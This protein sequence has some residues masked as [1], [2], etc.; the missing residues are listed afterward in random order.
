M[1]AFRLSALVLALYSCNLARPVADAPLSDVKTVESVHHSGK[2]LLWWSPDGDKF[3]VKP[4]EETVPKQ[5]ID[6]LEQM[7]ALCKGTAE[8]TATTRA[9][10]AP[11]MLEIVSDD[12]GFDAVLKDEAK[13]TL[14]AEIQSEIS[15]NEWT[16]GDVEADLASL[17]GQLKDLVQNLDAVKKD[18]DKMRTTAEAAAQA[19]GRPATE[20]DLDLIFGTAYRDVLKALKTAE[21]A[22]DKKKSEVEKQLKA[23]QDVRKAIADARKKLE[24][25]IL[26]VLT[27]IAD[28]DKVTTVSLLQRE[29]LAFALLQTAAIRLKLIASHAPVNVTCKQVC[30]TE[31]PFY[32]R[33]RCYSCRCKEAMDGS[34]PKPEE[35]SCKTAKQIKVYK[36]KTGAQGFELGE[37]E[38][39]ADP[40]AC[41]NPSLLYGD[42]QYGSKLGQLTKGDITYKW[43]CRHRSHPTAAD[44]TYDDVGVIAHNATTGASCW[45]DD[46]GGI[47]TDDKF[48]KLDLTS[49]TQAEID[50]NKEVFYNTTGEGCTGCHDNDPFM[51]S[52]YF[53][54]L[55]WKTGSYVDASYT[56]TQLDGKQ[57]KVERSFLASDEAGACVSCHRIASGSTCASWAGQSMGTEKGDGVEELVHKALDVTPTSGARKAGENWQL[58]Y[59]MPITKGFIKG[60][61]EKWHEKYGEAKTHIEKCCANPQATGCKWVDHQGAE[62]TASTFQDLPDFPTPED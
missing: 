32:D 52:P 44:A 54:S 1:A 62:V 13:R 29:N 39:G 36:L 24:D 45:W 14:M 46:G 57:E 53:A 3:Y 49:A 48:P 11:M 18:L 26:E 43:I 60:T 51:Y 19:A 35:L 5:R 23:H 56:T 2:I 31:S 41:F 8:P 4:C 33:T 30:E 61:F 38:P 55:D 40:E 42:C 7:K 9:V 27:W 37:T 6:T 58:A 17:E 10:L 28:K 50:F 20:D 22:S 47:I 15:D 12:A 59:W 21:T 34:L 25:V 16:A